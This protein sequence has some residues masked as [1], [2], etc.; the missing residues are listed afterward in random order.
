MT[1]LLIRTL[2]LPALAAC[3]LVLL[4][5]C[6]GGGGS[7]RGPVQTSPD[8]V[9]P[10]PPPAPEPTLAT[11]FTDLVAAT[12]GNAPGWG[13]WTAPAGR[14]PVSGVA[15]TGTITYHQHSLVS[16]YKEGTRLGLPDNLGRG[17]CT[18]EL[19][20]HDVMGM[21]HMEADVAKKFTL[22]Q[23]F[24]LW[25]QPLGVNGT[26]GLAGPVRFYLVENEK[27]TRYTGDPAALELVPHREIVIVSGA[28]PAVLPKY[29]WPSGL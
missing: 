14:V 25:G 11:T 23:L 27:L 2:R 21:V 16:I 3:S 15:C 17:G 8:P 4:A 7:D 1:N 13:T 24:A 22:A 6:G 10:S 9:Q 20:T 18:Y 26:A 28:A 5:A 29:R 19:H 12:S